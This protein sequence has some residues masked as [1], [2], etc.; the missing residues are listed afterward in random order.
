[1][2]NIKVHSSYTNYALN[3]WCFRHTRHTK[4]EKLNLKTCKFRFLCVLM[5]WYYFWY[6]GF[7]FT[8][9]AVIQNGTLIWNPA[10][11]FY[12]NYFHYTWKKNV[13]PVFGI[14]IKSS[15]PEK[16][17]VWISLRKKN[18]SS[19][20]RKMCIQTFFILCNQM[21]PVEML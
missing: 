9:P 10:Q 8:T 17:G 15:C 14:N 1:M 2:Q 12:H 21:G 19:F 13:W 18:E 3:V 5:L 16:F 7:Y 6:L 20:K 4:N 11:L